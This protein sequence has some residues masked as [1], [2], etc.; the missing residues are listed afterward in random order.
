MENKK[1][2]LYYDEASKYGRKTALIQMIPGKNFHAV[3]HFD[4]DFGTAERKFV[5]EKLL[6][7]VLLKAKYC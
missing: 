4:E 5:W 2:I 1:A 7:I 3:G 6:N